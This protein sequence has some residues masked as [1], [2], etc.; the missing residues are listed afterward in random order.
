[1]PTPTPSISENKVE[2][3]VERIYRASDL[4]VLQDLSDVLKPSVQELKTLVDSMQV[5]EKAMYK[6]WNSKPLFHPFAKKAK[7]TATQT[8]ALQ[9]H[10]HLYNLANEYWATFQSKQE[11]KD[12][13]QYWEIQ[14]EI[15][16]ITRDLK[17]G[18]DVMDGKVLKTA[19]G[20]AEERVF[21]AKKIVSNSK[22]VLG[23]ME[24]FLTAFEAINKATIGQIA[25]L[26]EEKKIEEKIA[27]GEIEGVQRKPWE[28]ERQEEL[29]R[30]RSTALPDTLLPRM[31]IMEDLKNFRQRMDNPKEPKNLNDLIAELQECFY[32]HEKISTHNPFKKLGNTFSRRVK[33]LEPDN[34][35]HILELCKS[36]PESLQ[37]SIDE[38]EESGKLA[39]KD[40]A[41]ILRYKK[42][43]ETSMAKVIGG[44]M[45]TH[46][47][48]IKYNFDLS[49]NILH[50]LEK[51]QNI[52]EGREPK[53]RGL[54]TSILTKPK[55]QSYTEK[56]K[57]KDASSEKRTR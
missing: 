14:R 34:M 21:E 3:I 47:A 56:A 8:Q 7:M 55:A 31:R 54:F 19:D 11:T 46:W 45:Q 35:D 20:I 25:L 1:M 37:K 17:S 44:E 33:T 2:A 38:G 10:I 23:Q 27:S 16:Q 51:S 5:A 42:T 4:N 9:N 32:K 40:L 49:K 13:P 22:S 50:A 52:I 18:L 48:A 28:E 41:K 53:K 43:I 26:E 15:E 29:P 6:L 24:S 30:S 12:F 36:A 39:E 57:S